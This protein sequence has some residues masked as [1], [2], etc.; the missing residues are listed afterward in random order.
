MYS[1]QDSSK[2]TSQSAE[3]FGF[4]TTYLHTKN[5]PKARYKQLELHLLAICTSRANNLY[6]HEL[7]YLYIVLMLISLVI[8]TF[9]IIEVAGLQKTSVGVIKI[10][11]KFCT[12]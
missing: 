12:T 7:G 1:Y 11:V 5:F 10:S 4:V 6:F 8:N 2:P 9:N 3:A